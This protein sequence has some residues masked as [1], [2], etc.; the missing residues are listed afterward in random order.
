CV[1]VHSTISLHD[2][3]PIYGASGVEEPNHVGG[4]LAVYPHQAE[5]L[6]TAL[7]HDDLAAL[8]AT[9]P[10]NLFYVSGYRSPAPA[11][12]RTTELF[13]VFAPHGTALVVPAIPGP[14][15]AVELAAADHVVCYG[16]F[17]DG[18]GERRDE[19]ASRATARL[20]EP[21]G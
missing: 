15:V 16:A 9:T 21:V 2:A 10:A 13:A 12:D 8:V 7:E 20:R 1:P 3:L 19:S 17:A 4:A 6:T 18:V 14:A 11:V 5:R